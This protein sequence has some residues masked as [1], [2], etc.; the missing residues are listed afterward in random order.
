MEINFQLT[1]GVPQPSTNWNNWAANNPTAATENHDCARQGGI[2]KDFKE[3]DQ[4][5]DLCH[6]YVCVKRK[7]KEQQLISCH[8]YVCC[9]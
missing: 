4:T 3:Y 8:Q 2:S 1:V 6:L 7:L 5:C 9:R